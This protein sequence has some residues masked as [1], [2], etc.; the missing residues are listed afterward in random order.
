MCG[1]RELGVAVERLEDRSLLSGAN[2][3]VDI[4]EQLIDLSTGDGSSSGPSYLV[5]I[6]GTLFFAAGDNETGLELWKSDGTAAGTV[7]VKDINVGSSGSFPSDLTNVG[8]TLFFTADDGIRGRALWKSDGTTEGTV[9]VKD[10]VGGLGIAGANFLVNVAGKLF[11]VTDN[12]FNGE[13][14]K[15]DGTEAGTVQVKDINLGGSSSDPRP[16]ESLGNT[17]FF[18]ADDGINGRELW[19]TDGTES[20]T[21]LVK[22]IHDGAGSSV[23]VASARLGNTLFFSATD[24]VGGIELWKSD[25]TESGTVLV[26]D[27]NVGDGNSFPTYLTEVGGTLFFAADDGVNG[28]ELWMTDG[29]AAGTVLVKDI[30][31]SNPSIFGSRPVELTNFGGTLF[32]SAD[33]GVHGEELWKSDGTE[34][35]T[36]LVSDI[37]PLF[38]LSSNPS[39]LTTFGSTLFFRANGLGLGREL[40]KVEG[41]VGSPVLVR[42]IN[43]SLDSPELFNSNPDDFTPL[44]GM[45]LFTATDG[46]NGVELWK[47]DGTTGGTVLVKDINSSNLDSQSP[48]NLGPVA[49]LGD[50]LFFSAADGVSFGGTLR[51]SDGT[52]GGTRLVRDAADFPDGPNPFS[53]RELTTVGNQIFF[54]AE[55]FV[56][57]IATGRELWVTDGTELGTVLVMNIYEEVESGGVFFVNGSNPR[58][59]TD[60]GGTVLFSATD[61]IHG[62]EL[63]KSSGS[64]GA[65]LVK[66]INTANGTNAYASSSPDYLTT[67]GGLLFF[68]ANDGVN[69]TE[70]W[71]SDGT[72]GG[73]V[74]VKD[75]FEGTSGSAPRELTN[76]NGTL[77][78]VAND[79]LNGDELWKSDGTVEGTVLVKNLRDG[80]LTSFPANLTAVGNTLFFTA[81]DNDHGYELWKS[82]GTEA[83]TVLVKDIN[84]TSV[85]FGS[86]RPSNL[87]NVDGRLFFTAEDG[88]HGDELWTSDGSAAGT[89]LVRDI[90]AGGDHSGISQLTDVG[91]RLYFRA[92]NGITGDEVWRSDGTTGGTIIVAD[93]G[94]DGGSNPQNFINVNGRLFFTATDNE[95]GNELRLFT[96]TANQFDPVF[97]S[98]ATPSVAENTTAVLTVAAT[99]EDTPA[100]PVTFSITGGADQSKF[101]ITEAGVLTFRVAPNFEI[102]TDADG[103]NIYL[104]QVTSNDGNGGI[105]AQNLSVTVNDANDSP[106][107][108]SSATPF[109]VEHQTAVLTV[110][111]TDA[112]LPA[113]TIT[114]SLT[115]GADQSQFAITS[116]GRLTFVTAPD[117][118]TPTDANGDNVYLVHVTANDGNGGTAVQNLSVTVTEQFFLVK[119]IRAGNEGAT[120]SELVRLGDTL[121]FSADD[122]IHG[123][124]LWKSDGTEAGTVLVKN[125]RAGSL[126]S[127]PSDLTIVG[128]TLFFVAN[129]GVNGRELW[130]SDGTEAG[131]VLVKNIATGALGSSPSELT[132]VGGTLFFSVLFGN[133]G[134][135]EL[136]KSDGTETGTVLVQEGNGSFGSFAFDLTNVGGAVFFR[137]FNDSTFTDELWISDGTDVG[138]VLV[139][140]GPSSF[141]GFASFLASFE[142]SLFFLAN[143]G[144]NGEELWTSDGTTAGTV[145]VKDL[146]SGASASYLYPLTV[147][148]NTLFFAA[149]NGTNG[150]ELWKSDGTSAGTVLV[151]DIRPGSE[152]SSLDGLTNVNGTLFFSAD[153]G[154]N[155]VELWKSDGTA[156]GTVL[157]QNIRAGSDS[158]HPSSLTNV[159]GTLVFAANVSFSDA[160]L[161]QSDGTA[162]GTLL[163]TNF[164]HPNPELFGIPSLRLLTDVDGRAF[165][166]ATDSTHGE[167]LWL[168]NPAPA[169]EPEPTPSV[170]LSVTPDT[171]AEAAGTATV[172]ATL[173]GP[174]SE[175]VTVVL[176]FSG[177]AT[178]VSDYTR[179]GSQIV[180]AAGNTTGSITLTA[181]QDTRDEANETI[182]VEITEVTNGTESGTQQVTA[183]ITDDDAPPT[184]ALGIS[185]ATLAEAGGT[186][187]VTATLSTASSF[188][189]T[190]DLGFS[191][192]ATNVSDY[193]RSNTQ[194]VIA[195]GSTTGSITLTAVQDTL[196]EENETIVVEI[197]NVTNGTESGTQTVTGTIVS[198][199]TEVAVSLSPSSV[200]ENGTSNLVYSFTRT[201]ITTS[202]MTVNFS[203][204]GTATLTTD[205]TQTGAATFGAAA[206]TIT[207]AANQTTKTIT[208]DPKADTT[209]EADE[210]VILTVTPSARYSV[211][212]S[213]SATGTITNDDFPKITLAASP[214]SVLENGTGNL[215][216]TF[217]RPGPTNSPL[218]VNF[219]VGGT[220]TLDSDYTANGAASFSATNGSVTFGVG[221]ATKTITIDPTGDATVEPNETILLQLI[222]GSGYLLGTLTP[223][224]TTITNDDAEVSITVS[225]NNV[226]EDGTPNLVYTFTRVGATPPLT[227]N[228]TVGG[229]ATLT[230]DYAQSGAATFTAST[231]TLS[232]SAGQATKTITINPA[233]DALIEPDE[234]VILTLAPAANYSIGSANAATGT[235]LNDD[236]RVSVAVSPAAV[237]E[238]GTTNATYTFTR[239]GST[240]SPLTVNFDV[241]GTAILTTDYI[242]TGAATF[243]DS[244]GSVTFA[245]GQ[246]TTTIVIDPTGDSVVEPNETVVLTLSAGAGY[247]IGTPTATTATITNDD[248]EISLAVS[249]DSVTEDGTPN[250]V[251]TFIRTG[252]TAGALTVNFS[253]A[254]TASRTT[255]YAPSGSATFTATAGTVSFSAGQTTKSV[256]INPT[257]DVLIEPDETVILTLTSAATYSIGAVNTVTGTITN[258]DPRVSVAVSPVSVAENGT[259]NALYTFKRT[260]PTTTPLTVAFDVG[261]TATFN[262]DYAA[263]GADS[264]GESSG[265][266]TFAAGQASKTIVIDP[267]GDALVEANETVVLTIAAGVDYVIG[268]PIA[269]TATIT[270]DDT[271]VSVAV[272]PDSVTENG[273]PNLVFTFTRIGVTT[274]SLTVNFTVGGTATFANDYSQTGAAAFN[275][276]TGRISFSANQ[277]TKTIT[278]NPAGDTVVESDETVILTIVPGATYTAGDPNSIIATILNDDGLLDD[279][280]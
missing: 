159:G 152:S 207:F 10:F 147:V 211:G 191:G 181:V 33:D 182:V 157:V 140:A 217:T 261:G 258:D 194:I 240:A 236:P 40:W 23:Q 134:G 188:D 225:P 6:N 226:T 254:G 67:V 239:T 250:L 199:D 86:S 201:G 110:M 108:T 272:S 171:L 229:T 277:L 32:F 230:T 274:N 180:I 165:F 192:T 128:D 88:I 212:T 99:D 265:T 105:V 52:I 262:T 42:D 131:T 15:S 204:S 3:V 195:A 65:L 46:V 68:S 133:S 28:N 122:G 121:F 198:D 93:I 113:Q 73:T 137:A 111:A 132:D 143:D 279:L 25:G 19:K 24:G 48:F 45:L 58:S 232:F 7:R 35:G 175:N 172:T 231:G 256:T 104:V 155:G 214:A 205:Y 115:G 117:F 90:R 234:T 79:G 252:S 255:D 242:A 197:L 97:T 163:A 246:A 85:S 209:I 193:T 54:S 89:V 228:F 125:I 118:D 169:P 245:A 219:T 66:D 41:T 126:S 202:V 259:A 154:I 87:T 2:L 29:T 5:E 220:A 38:S 109:V 69:G 271:A 53:E 278:I 251:Y 173:S 273:T 56:D 166:L 174:A 153:D 50:T 37:N 156:A 98:S 233:A 18:S 183:T 187:T 203:V 51:R 218:T 162:T 72:D 257:A 260:G 196:S 30:D 27:I 139:A 136:W 222:A 14:W 149:D 82:D 81:E 100:Q 83:G 60:L 179:S 102:P 221:Q 227:V 266:F 269:A 148:G 64:S 150:R 184:V 200:T 1:P 141:G 138:T 57:G 158:S 94:D 119:D 216:Y 280:P 264:F 20:G 74:I 241:S 63:W 70:L 215:V 101:S 238:N 43:V 130:K 21:V 26:S 189:V 235:I 47:T 164:P 213:N 62:R 22:D 36:V 59:L 49:S 129:D 135:T 124:E 243:T 77:F 178:N 120:A 9:L 267:I 210:T 4:N 248:S 75:I 276:T 12:R 237:L 17:L 127:L 112:D 91:G 146:G 44:G 13:L 92:N 268:T 161:W 55:S 123:Q 116:G 168:F 103:N 224:T 8:G 78:F 16:L 185:A 170:T 71:K 275:A 11:F 31:A 39:D 190:V 186:S 107:I 80:A 206:G 247:V 167:E 223:V 142:D 263:T 208:I 114:Y 160:E 151:E 145:L 270:N 96:P 176:G 106:V 249:P 84:T 61:G 253:V 144:V 95:F 34:A 76:V 177:T 244:T